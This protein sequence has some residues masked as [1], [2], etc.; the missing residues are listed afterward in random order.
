MKVIFFGIPD[1]GLICLGELIK[2]KTNI[3]AVVPPVPNHP[4]HKLMVNTAKQNG[5]SSL[6]FKTSPKEPT[7]IDSFRRL[8]PDLAVVCAFDHLLPEELLEIPPLGFINCHPSLLPDYRGGN[9]YFHVIANGEKETGITVHYMDKTFDT[10][11]VI[12]Q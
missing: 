5:I 7:F 4:T 12:C 2:R 8:Q 11:D 9:P 1:L 3:I 6:F 10:G